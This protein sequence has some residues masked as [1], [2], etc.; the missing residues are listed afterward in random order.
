MALQEASSGSTQAGRDRSL[1]PTS[2]RATKRC[3]LHQSQAWSRKVIARTILRGSYRTWFKSTKEQVK[4]IWSEKAQ[5]R[6]RSGWTRW[7]WSNSHSRRN[8]R[9]SKMWVMWPRLTMSKLATSLSQ[10]F[11]K[12]LFKKKMTEWVKRYSF[13]LKSK[14][15]NVFYIIIL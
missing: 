1:A 9:S 11:K 5:S 4:K 8:S 13:P 2:R 12:P 10:V 6:R 14:P 3:A 7:T 15:T